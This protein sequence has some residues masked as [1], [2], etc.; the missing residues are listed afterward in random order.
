[1]HMVIRA[2]YGQEGD[3]KHIQGMH[4][5]LHIIARPLTLQ[6]Y[7]GTCTLDYDRAPFEVY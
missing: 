4:Q 3:G 1:M 5:G 2:D 6:I 7:T